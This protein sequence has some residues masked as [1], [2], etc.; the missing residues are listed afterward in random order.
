[1]TDQPR[2]ALTFED[3]LLVPRRSSIRSRRHVSTRSRFT[4]GVELAIP[5]VSANMDTVTTAPMAIAMAELGGDPS[6]INPLQPV[7]LVI[8]HS[9]QVDA[10][11]TPE[12][13]EQN[14]ELAEREARVLS[15]LDHPALPRYVEHFEEG[16]ELF[17]VTEKI[18]GE[19]LLSLRKRG[20]RTSEAEVIRMNRPFSCSSGMLRAPT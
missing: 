14:V 20:V 13:F 6:R 11:G 17:L 16:G 7:E 18:E 1:M 8:D 9:I 10:F 4:R 3:V 19:N 12:A 15:S 5:I 2:L